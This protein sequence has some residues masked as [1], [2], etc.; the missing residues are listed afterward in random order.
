MGGLKFDKD[1]SYGEKLPWHLTPFEAIEGMIC[2]L[3]YGRRKYTVCG[4]CEAPIYPNPR[5]DGD[6]ERDDCPE[7]GSKQESGC[8]Q[9]GAATGPGAKFCPECGNKLA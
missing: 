1:A 9:C 3:Q 5:L 4:D 2:V 6:P 8:P 7:C